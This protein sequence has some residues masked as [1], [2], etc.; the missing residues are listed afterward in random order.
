MCSI[1]MRACANGSEFAEHDIRVNETEFWLIESF[2][3]PANDLEAEALP[4]P[5]GALVC[6]DH[7]IELHS[8]KASLTRTFERMGAHRASHAATRRMKRG[9]VS[10]IRNIIPAAPLIS[11]QEVRAHNFAVILRN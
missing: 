3:K 8:A 11:F 4:Q 9:H 7:K 1:A 6:A 5:D 2:W 10:T